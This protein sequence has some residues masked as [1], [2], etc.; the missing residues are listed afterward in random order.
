MYVES[1]ATSGAHANFSH[2][3][4]LGQRYQV[5]QQAGTGN[6]ARV[7]ECIDQ[8]SDE[9][10]A[11]KVFK[12]G[13]ERDADFEADVLR[14]CGRNDPKEESGIVKL[15]ER[16]DCNGYTMLVFALKGQ[17]LR[18]VRLPISQQAVADTIRDLAKALTFLHFTVRAV[19][20]DLKPE[21][22]LEE[23]GKA[24]RRWTICDFGSASFY[25]PAKLDTDLITTRPYR[26][27]EVVLSRGWSFAADTWS[28]GCIMYE[29]RT[30]KKLFD[31]HNDGD[32]LS[33]MVQRLGS[34]PA[35]MTSRYIS[36]PFAK[37]TTVPSLRDELRS[38]SIF[39]LLLLSMLEYDPN[40]RIRCDEVLK[41]EY[42]QQFSS[43]QHRRS[44]AQEPLVGVPS[45]AAGEP[46]ALRSTQASNAVP[47]ISN[48]KV[49]C[50]P[51][52]VVAPVKSNNNLS[53]PPTMPAAAAKSVAAILDERLSKL[54]ISADSKTTTPTTP[55]A[56]SLSKSS[57][58]NSM[59]S[60]MSPSVPAAGVDYRSAFS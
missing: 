37:F 9:R 4:V 24:N 57:S 48:K 45:P 1:H 39:L 46:L 25:T 2:G 6:F 29:L 7:F 20:T 58:Q 53:M 44:T 41:H 18:S 54:F 15:I 32:H 38:D 3:N 21:N 43:S 27:P 49:L 51:T 12:K 17:N 23:R 13:F 55:A 52:M 22:I 50:M 26:A 33:L 42:L 35:N 34:L 30:G 56:T 11:V 40:K 60:M 10:V 59:R 36:N 31:V 28:L 47:E 5:V 8:K 19:H 16:L 14:A